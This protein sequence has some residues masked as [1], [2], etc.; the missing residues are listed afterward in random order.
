MQSGAYQASSVLMLVCSFVV[1]S[2]WC[3]FTSVLWFFLVS[4]PSH[5]EHTILATLLLVLPLMCSFKPVV[6]WPTLEPAT[7]ALSPAC[8]GS[9]W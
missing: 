3:S 6:P 8:S 1:D 2:N 5:T 7:G 4:P 9:P